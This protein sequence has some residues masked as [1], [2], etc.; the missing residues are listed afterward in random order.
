MLIVKLFI[1]QGDLMDIFA[2]TNNS[3]NFVL[4]CTMS[5]AFRS[6]FYSI[7]SKYCCCFTRL[8]ERIR[9]GCCKKSAELPSQPL[10]NNSKGSGQK[11]NFQAANCQIENVSSKKHLNEDAMGPK[12][13]NNLKNSNKIKRNVSF[14]SIEMK[15]I[16]NNQI[17]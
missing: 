12:I 15:S 6:T 14:S 10:I 3:I 9:K 5:R 4:Y 17:T 1:I 16:T 2:L 13:T 8:S 7:I 11:I